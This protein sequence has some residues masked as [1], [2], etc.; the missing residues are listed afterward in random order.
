[1]DRKQQKKNKKSKKVPVGHV[2]SD[3]SDDEPLILKHSN[4][5]FDVKKNLGRSHM[6]NSTPA[7]VR[8]ASPAIHQYHPAMYSPQVPMQ[9]PQMVMQQQY[10]NP[11]FQYSPMQQQQYVNPALQYAPM[12]QQMVNPALQYSPAMQQQYMVTPVQ[13][14]TMMHQP[15]AQPKQSFW[16]PAQGKLDLQS[17]TSSQSSMRRK[18]A[19]KPK[20]RESLDI[21]SNPGSKLNTANLKSA[22]SPKKSV[23]DAQLSPKSERDVVVRKSISLALDTSSVKKNRSSISAPLKNN[24]NL[25]IEMESGSDDD[26][27]LAQTQKQKAISNR[28]SID[29]RK[30]LME[31]TNSNATNLKSTESP[32]SPLEKKPSFFKRI[33]GGFKKK[34]KETVSSKIQPDTKELLPPIGSKSIEPISQTFKSSL[35]PKSTLS[36]DTLTDT[37]FNNTDFGFDFD[38]LLSRLDN[39]SAN[40]DYPTFKPDKKKE[41]RGSADSIDPSL[42]EFKRFI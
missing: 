6:G 12:Q 20:K 16:V 1:M 32:K 13:Q 42:L 27:P 34:S 25:K 4:R 35:D 26:V 15:Q 37:T 9:S 29:S 3:S 14:P 2:E 17:E 24:S 28:R 36:T 5:S 30:T 23:S 38:N 21:S 11:A 33:F 10:V 41:L 40:N 18:K 19:N 22:K 31:I 8:V 7:L 39:P